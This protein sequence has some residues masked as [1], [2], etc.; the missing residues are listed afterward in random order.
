[1][2][3]KITAGIFKN[4]NVTPIYVSIVCVLMPAVSTCLL[5]NHVDASGVFKYSDDT[6][7][8]I[9]TLGVKRINITLIITNVH[10]NEMVN[11]SAYEM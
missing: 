1:M 2:P 6:F 3:S 9:S 11:S 4:K 5:A 8:V 10:T 7:L